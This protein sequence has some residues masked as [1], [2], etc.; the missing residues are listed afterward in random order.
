MFLYNKSLAERHHKADSEKTAKQCDEE[1]SDNARVINLSFLCPEEKCRQCE[2]R[3]CCKRLTGRTDCLYE[4][5]LKDGIPAKD[6]TDDSHRDNCRRNRSG[7]C[8]TNEKTDV[9]IRCAEYNCK[10][11]TDE[12]RGYRKFR[13]DLVRRDIRLEL[14]FVVHVTYIP[15]FCFL[16]TS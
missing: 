5:V 7:D 1:D 9:C 13:D 10:D 3:A 12:N 6:H 4:V 11:D 16:T 2:D 8:H 14:I 15:F